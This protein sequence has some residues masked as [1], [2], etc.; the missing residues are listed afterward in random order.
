MKP[1]RPLSNRDDALKTSTSAMV[2]EPNQYL[3]AVL[4][5][6]RVPKMISGD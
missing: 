6:A 1:T 3:D 2:T 5:L 4:L